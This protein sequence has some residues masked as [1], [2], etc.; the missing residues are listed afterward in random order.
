MSEANAAIVTAT[1]AV[2]AAEEGMQADGEQS[3][4]DLRTSKC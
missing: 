3:R 4:L 2:K 1:G